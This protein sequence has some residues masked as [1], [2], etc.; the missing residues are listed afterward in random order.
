[1]AWP[2]ID[3]V[4]PAEVPDYYDVIKDPMGKNCVKVSRFPVNAASRETLFE[5]H[6]VC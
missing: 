2:F 5:E 3:P 6:L 1:M 4:D